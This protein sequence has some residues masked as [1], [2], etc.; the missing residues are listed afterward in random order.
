MAEDDYTV[1]LGNN[2]ITNCAAALVIEGVEV[3][4][5]REDDGQLLVDCDVLNH[6]GQR[7]A[8]IVRNTPIVVADGF[9]AHIKPG[10][11]TEVIY[12][13]NGQ[14]VA[15]FERKGPR[16]VKITG[17]FCVNGY[18]VFIDDEAGLRTNEEAFTFSNNRVRGFGTAISL[19]RGQIGIG[20]SGRQ[21]K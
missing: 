11:P 2:D 10:E 1:T 21:S 13:E 16:H 15:R 17:V 6:E 9:R 7:M 20:F 8:K 5:L 19:K 14:V 4:R 3:F 18:C 12:E